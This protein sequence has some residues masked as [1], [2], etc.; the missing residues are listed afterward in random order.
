MRLLYFLLLLPL[1]LWSQ[2]KTDIPQTHQE[3]CF[4]ALE[5]EGFQEYLNLRKD[6]EKGHYRLAA[7]QLR[8][9]I[10]AL[11]QFKVNEHRHSFRIWYQTLYEDYD[12][13]LANT[14]RST[15]AFLED[16]ERRLHKGDLRFFE[17]QRFL[18]ELLAYRAEYFYP[19]FW[20]MS[21]DRYFS[22]AFVKTFTDKNP[23]AEKLFQYSDFFIAFSYFDCLLEKEER[24]L[25]QQLNIGPYG[26]D[27]RGIGQ[28]ALIK[29]SYAQLPPATASYILSTFDIDDTT[30]DLNYNREMSELRRMLRRCKQGKIW[31][32][33]RFN[34]HPYRAQQ[35]K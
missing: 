23:E 35:E 19:A 17:Q 5:K 14:R 11:Q 2:Y 21:L 15:L 33:V 24:H 26:T 7:Q 6:M 30:P 13:Q 20:F 18:Q 32:V 1:P 28:Q 16:Y 10:R 29:Y 8:Q 12:E 34:E 25:Q 22:Q 4:W 31:L 9:M 3:V 27:P